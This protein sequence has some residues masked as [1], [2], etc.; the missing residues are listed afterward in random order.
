MM[1]QQCGAQTLTPAQA[2]GA[3]VSTCLGAIVGQPEQAV[4]F[5]M[6]D[7]T[8]KTFKVTASTDLM[9][10][11]T[12]GS[13]MTVFQLLGADGETATMKAIITHEGSFKSVSGTY[14]AN[15][16]LVPELKQMFTLM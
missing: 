11:F 8:L 2:D 9:M 10:S 14:R 7:G 15:S 5:N 4:A 16:F 12:S 3:I 6:A 13:R 1:A